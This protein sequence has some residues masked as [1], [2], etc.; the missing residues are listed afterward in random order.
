[1]EHFSF[2]DTKIEYGLQVTYDCEGQAFSADETDKNIKIERQTEQIAP[3]L[4][5]TRLKITNLSREQI[6]LKEA[7]PVLSE[8]IV[9]KKPSYEW[10]MLIHG[11]HKND[12]PSTCSANLRDERFRDAV[13]RLSEEGSLITDKIGESVTFYSDLLTIIKGEDSSAA[14]MVLSSGSQLTSCDVTVDKDGVFKELSFGGEFNCFVKSGDTR[15]TQWFAIDLRND[16]QKVTNDFAIERSKERIK[17]HSAPSVYCTWSYYGREITSEDVDIN[18]KKIEENPLPF[19]CFQIDAGWEICYG[20]WN[21][22][23]KFPDIEKTAQNI[24]S[25]G[26]M[27][28][29]WTCPFIADKESQVI[30]EHPEWILYHNDGTPC[31]FYAGKKQN[32]VLDLSN[33]GVLDWLKELYTKL[34]LWGYNYHKLDFTRSFPTQRDV[35][36]FNPFMT[37]VEAYVE[38]MRVI[39]GALGDDSYLEVCG[40]LYDPLIGIADAQ[41]TGSD[42]RSMWLDPSTGNPRIPMTIKQNVFR[43]FMND[44]WDNDPD[45]LM[46]RRN[47]NSVKPVFLDLGLLN[48]EEAKIFTLNQ[49]AGGGLVCSTEALDSIDE[50]RMMMLRHVMPVADTK[51]LPVNIFAADRYLKYVD[52]TVNN[53][54][55]TL[56]VFNWSDENMPVE[57]L[58]DENI[59]NGFVSKNKTYCVS[60][61]FSGKVIKNAAYGDCI[62]FAEIKPHSAAVIKIAERNEPHIVRSNMHFSMGGE[63][64]KLDICNDVLNIEFEHRYNYPLSY[65]VLLPDGYLFED[66][67]DSIDISAY[68]A[69]KIKLL[70]N[71]MKNFKRSDT[72]GKKKNDSGN[73]GM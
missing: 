58:L 30:S 37:N 47:E 16:W 29:I 68:K 55:H 72:D 25:T 59:C 38:A 18:V 50:D 36:K 40:G 5:K 15:Y 1:M 54:W 71:L 53:K 8:K 73:I 39:R 20:S 31:E 52:V 49:Y 42:V 44:W 6:F 3:Y 33:P 21:A 64:E 28:G 19:S 12:L 4:I 9:L 22:N 10:Q 43:Y 35:K 24:R 66:G 60:E 46:V 11:R 57:V 51:V 26:M 63:I 69:G 65:T 45:S 17:R 67:N 13:N 7:I 41:R 70:Y 34:V 14:F 23:E 62:N 2:G 61:F 56:C 48:D 27:A 32:Y